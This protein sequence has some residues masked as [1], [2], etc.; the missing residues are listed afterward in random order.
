M[1]GSVGKDVA[2]GGRETWELKFIF[3]DMQPQ[4]PTGLE[5]RRVETEV[6]LWSF[7]LGGPRMCPHSFEQLPASRNRFV[8]EERAEWG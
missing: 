3:S 6:R 1:T 7:L 5:E 2:Q 4:P 8:R